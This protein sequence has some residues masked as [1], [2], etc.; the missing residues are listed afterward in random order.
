MDGIRTRYELDATVEMSI[1]KHSR[2]SVLMSK[3]CEFFN[4]AEMK[5]ILV[6]IIKG[7]SPLSLRV[8]DFFVTNYARKNEVILKR[9]ESEDAFMVHY[10]YKAQLKA[11]SKKQ[12]D[13]F[14]RRE[15][16]IF[17]VE[18]GGK[19]TDRFKTTVGQLNFFRWAIQNNV[20]Q[21]IA[22]N[23]ATIEQEMNR[24]HIN[25]RRKIRRLKDRL[26]EGKLKEGKLKERQAG[27]LKKDRPEKDG[28]DHEDEES[29]GDDDGCC[30]EEKLIVD[31]GQHGDAM[32]T[33]Q[34]TKKV[35][36]H[37]VTITV[38]FD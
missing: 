23:L 8:I 34:A 13:P 16:I 1:S 3:I 11:Y 30:D 17:I 37:N 27:Q 22:A 19:E 7:E 2:R 21:H 33:V 31:I 24:T 12:F 38:K 6:S 35:S 29:C 32:T 9:S 10:S 28:D 4:D 25:G 14:C 15:R 36:K 26:K 5:D 20:M 18:D